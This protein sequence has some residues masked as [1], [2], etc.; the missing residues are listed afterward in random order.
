MK[1]VFR[2]DC[3]SKIGIGHLIRSLALASYYP[4]DQIYFIIKENSGFEL[5]KKRIIAN[6]YFYYGITSGDQNITLNINTFLGENWKNDVIKTITVLDKIKIDGCNSIDW[7]IID[8]YGINYQW[9]T[10]LKP[11]VKNLMVI[12]DYLDRKHNCNN[13]LNFNNDIIP[14]WCD[15]SIVCYYGI[16]YTLIS[17]KFFESTINKTFP[18]KIKTILISFGGSDQTKMVGKIIKLCSNKDY[19]D[20]KFNVVIGPM[21]QLNEIK[22]ILSKLDNFHLHYNLSYPE[23]IKLYME[24]DLAIGSLGGSLYEKILLKIPSINFQT[25]DNQKVLVKRFGK[26]VI[27]INQINNQLIDQDFNQILSNFIS[28]PNYW[29]SEIGKLE[30]YQMLRKEINENLSTLLSF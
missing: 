26:D 15:K 28:S 1:I 22:E 17:K 29:K 24:T 9:E 4:N 20:V 25:A 27:I 8:H 12:D 13:Y 11:L 21:T 19:S 18:S 7:L 23:M 30:K 3:G 2:L 16:K 14:D 6:N 5:I 10:A